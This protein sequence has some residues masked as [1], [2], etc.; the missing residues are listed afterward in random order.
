MTR[1]TAVVLA[2]LTWLFAAGPA[3]RAAEVS[4]ELRLWH[5]VT[6][7]FAGPA[8]AEDATPN[9]FRD[10][11]LDVT[12]T[13]PASGESR[14]VPGFFA[15]DGNAAETSA[16]A[17]DRWSV[18]FSPSREGLWRW[19]VRFRHGRDVAIAGDATDGEPW[20]PLDGL[21]GELRIGPTDK[22]PPDFR[23]RGTLEYAG[24]RYLRFAGDGTL[25]LKGGVGSPE[26]LL[27]YADFDGTW[28][29]RVTDRRPPAPHPPISLPSLRDGLHRYEPHLRDWRPGD[30]AWKDGK[31]KGLVGGL[32]YLASQGVNA[33]YFL[34]MNVNGDGRNVWPWTDPGTR[35]RFDASKLDQW[36]IVFSHMTRLGLMLHVVTQET[37]NDHLLDRGDLGPER[38]L[39]YRELVARF[40]HHPAMTWNLGEENVQSPDQQ[41][42]MAAELRRLD[43]YRHHVVVHNDHWHAKNLRETFDPLVGFP[44]ITGTAIQDFHWND[45]HSHV[46][47][48]VRASA[49]AG[50]P[51]VVAADELGG[52]G[53]GTLPDADDAAHDA[54]R[55]FGLWGTLMAGGAGVEWYFGWQN[56]SPHS[57]LS[58]EDWRTREAMYRQT[59]LALEFFHEHLPFD[60]MEPAD[61]AMVGHGVFALAAPGEV[62]AIYLPNGGATRLDLGP[63]AGLYE[64]R[65]FDPRAGGPLREGSVKRVRGPGLAWTG[66]PPS[67]PHRD[68]L[69]LVRRVEET[70]PAME[71]PADEWRRAAP[72]DLGIDPVGLEHALGYWR[73]ATGAEG[74]DRVVVARRGVVVHEGKEAGREQGVWSV[75]KS[76][77]S[78]ALGL[79]IAEMGFSVD[80]FA[81]DFEPLLRERYPRATLRHFAT[82]TS[83]YSAPGGSRWG[84]PS[85][86]WSNEPFVPGP[87]LFAPGEAFA[88][89][90]EAQMMLGRVLTRLGRRDLLAVLDER[91]LRPIGARVAGWSTEGEVER[92]PIRNG[93]TGITIDARN[94][95]RFGHLFLNGGRWRDTQVV[96]A[97]WVREATRPQVGAGLPIADTDRRA[98]DGRGVYG[99]N[100][101]TNGRRAD[102]RL[103]LPDAP[104]GTF[105]AAGLHHNILLVVPEWEMVIVRLGE[106]PNPEGGHA[107]VLNAFLRRLGMAVHPLNE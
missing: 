25:F 11:R 70:A 68:W 27:G 57:D 16:A 48:Y 3:V 23:A 15:A 97:E 8:T 51:W 77:T 76:F 22:R 44:P 103:A 94:L 4:G 7:T 107:G 60:R 83:G 19:R 85:E 2:C 50:H 67:D 36:E 31:G 87:P 58:A 81:A 35:D 75:T 79:L 9:P 72:F 34:T 12:F 32:N 95:A 42:A 41:R 29:D 38:R 86:D 106:G 84:E 10:Y 73:M 78:T 55:R 17:G 54:P 96:P 92:V 89:W 18:H 6:L 64:V 40:A 105:Y 14:A 61:E 62:Y 71:F 24:G 104:P 65:W 37:E 47:H 59:R 88:Y 69:A 63:R 80:A 30:P 45:V 93:C 74:V 1:A 91:V 100:W 102:G 21:A 46:K 56:N 13:H 33:V 49:A 90:D 20:K 66:D 43:P 101:W 98:T 53:F 82:M 5:R 99:L 52:A 39:Y 28:L 26:T